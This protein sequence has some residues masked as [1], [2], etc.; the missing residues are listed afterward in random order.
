[1]AV[2]VFDSAIWLFIL[3]IEPAMGLKLVLILFLLYLFCTH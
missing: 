3:N 2:V 1:M